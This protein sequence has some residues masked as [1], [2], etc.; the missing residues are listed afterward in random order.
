MDRPEGVVGLDAAGEDAL[1]RKRRLPCRQKA[2]ARQGA[3]RGGAVPLRVAAGAELGG[4]GSAGA[5]QAADH[6]LGQPGP[7]PHQP[8]AIRRDRHVHLPVRGLG[9]VEAEL[10]AELAATEVEPLAEGVLGPGALVAD[11]AVDPDDGVAAA[12]IS[13]DLGQDLPEV[14][15]GVDDE[16]GAP[17]AV[18]GTEAAGVDVAV[19]DVVPGDDEAVVAADG[20]RRLEAQPA[21]ERPRRQVGA[22][23]R[24]GGAP[25]EVETPGGDADGAAAGLR[26]GCSS[27]PRRTPR[28]R[29]P[30]PGGRRRSPRRTERG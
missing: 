12:R 11:V 24:P 22:H 29:P 18:A 4:K 17:R 21:R 9:L 2:A 27:R 25:L 6:E 20:H 1:L 19:V 8:L 15:G 13:G 26:V 28:G 16:V 5:R 23:H 30:P 14:A 3:D 10:A 7:P